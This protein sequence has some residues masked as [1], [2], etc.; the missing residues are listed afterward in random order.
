MENN[1]IRRSVY[2]A[3][4]IAVSYIAAKTVPFWL[5]TGFAIVGVYVVIHAALKIACEPRSTIRDADHRQWMRE[6]A[7]R[8][9]DEPVTPDAKHILAIVRAR[10]NA[11]D[12]PMITPPPRP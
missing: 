9:D 11:E 12:A 5:S 4:L 10:M 2:V 8:D 3:A 7:D 6:Q 1:P